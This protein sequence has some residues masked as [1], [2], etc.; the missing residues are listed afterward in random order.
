MA[1]KTPAAAISPASDNPK[2]IQWAHGLVTA[3]KKSGTGDSTLNVI[4]A[5]MVERASDPAHA[6]LP[7]KHADRHLTAREAVAVLERDLPTHTITIDKARQYAET[8]TY[9]LPPPTAAAVDL[10]PLPPDEDAPERELPVADVQDLMQIAGVKDKVAGI[11]NV[12][13]EID[14]VG[15][16]PVVR[17]GTVK[18]GG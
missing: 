6:K 2:P 5:A 10:L 1:E 4:R 11:H 13:S 17:R 12:N 15:P 16:K 7:P 8:G 9:I 18:V 3:L 14:T